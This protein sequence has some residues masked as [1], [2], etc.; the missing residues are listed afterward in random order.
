MSVVELARGWVL[1]LAFA[2]RCKLAGPKKDDRAKSGLS[3]SENVGKQ[4]A[5]LSTTENN[6]S[7]F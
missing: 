5:L 7:R 1:R 3:N 6:S 4:D 2:G